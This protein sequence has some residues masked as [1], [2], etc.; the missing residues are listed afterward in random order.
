M[1]TTNLD[2][3]ILAWHSG[4]Q[5][6]QN[7]IVVEEETLDEGICLIRFP[8]DPSQQTIKLDIRRIKNIWMKTDD[9]D[10]DD[11]SCTVLI[12]NGHKQYGEYW[13]LIWSFHI[14]FIYEKHG[15]RAGTSR[16]WSLFQ[17]AQTIAPSKADHHS[18]ANCSIRAHAHSS[19]PQ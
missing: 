14:H 12:G 16:P 8:S 1:S 15:E 3:P 5:S 19:V 4:V 9:L 17:N 13:Y 2:Q 7:A 11:D 10:S 18:Y 6:W